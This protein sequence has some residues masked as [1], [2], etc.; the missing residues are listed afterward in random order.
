MSIFTADAPYAEYGLATG[1]NDLEQLEMTIDK[2]LK[3]DKASLPKLPSPTNAT[4]TIMKE[5]L[6]LTS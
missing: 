2:V 1:V 6:A 5:I 3:Q 4:D